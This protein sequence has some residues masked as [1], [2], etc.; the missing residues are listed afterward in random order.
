[1]S[2][3]LSTASHSQCKR[4]QDL[5]I[6]IST[7]DA[8]CNLCPPSSALEFRMTFVTHN[9]GRHVTCGALNGTIAPIVE[10]LPSGGSLFAEGGGLI[11][12]SMRT[13]KSGAELQRC[14]S[15]AMSEPCN[16]CDSAMLCKEDSRH[17][18]EGRR[19]EGARY[20]MIQ[21]QG[22]LFPPSELRECDFTLNKISAPAVPVVFAERLQAIPPSSAHC[23]H[24]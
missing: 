8:M 9:L 12:P 4:H 22:L 19:Q 15:T 10:L 20:T 13:R 2:N 11:C 5:E 24:L 6:I 18:Q 3:G 21:E 23:C 14:M 7:R 16:S 17:C 1:M